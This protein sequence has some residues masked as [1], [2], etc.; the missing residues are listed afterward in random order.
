MKILLTSCH[1]KPVAASLPPP[2]PPRSQMLHQ[3]VVALRTPMHANNPTP[4]MRWSQYV[5]SPGC[6]KHGNVYLRGRPHTSLLPVGVSL[7]S[8]A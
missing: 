6:N 5:A 1:P 4:N 7:N 8:A 3:G 2:P